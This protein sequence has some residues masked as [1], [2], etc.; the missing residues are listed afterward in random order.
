MKLSCSICR[1]NLAM[2]SSW[3]TLGVCAL[4]GRVL[5]SFLSVPSSV[6]KN[7][8][9]ENNE[10]GI[11]HAISKEK[12]A[13]LSQLDSFFLCHSNQRI[14]FVR[15]RLDT[16]TTNDNSFLSFRRIRIYDEKYWF[17]KLQL[18]LVFVNPFKC[19]RSRETNI[20]I[21]NVYE[22]VR[23]VTTCFEPPWIK[24]K[25]KGTKLNDNYQLKYRD[26]VDL[27]KFNPA[28]VQFRFCHCQCQSFKSIGDHKLFA[29]N[30]QFSR[31]RGKHD[32]SLPP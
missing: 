25:M 26:E 20:S 14:V 10:T 8:P 27:R 22:S 7:S 12:Y 32:F 28:T 24:I 1:R 29:S 31:F 2:F 4:E 23:T 13:L 11:T 19:P 16:T 18:S 6:E 3:G 9:N 5:F 15:A 30:F 21:L 17:P